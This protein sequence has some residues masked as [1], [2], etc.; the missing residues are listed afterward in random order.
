MPGV[1]YPTELCNTLTPNPLPPREGEGF[2]K[3]GSGNATQRP[4]IPLWHGYG[5]SGGLSLI[6]TLS[7]HSESF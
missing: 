3:G 1:L 6:Q 4:T 7:R 5:F 2:G